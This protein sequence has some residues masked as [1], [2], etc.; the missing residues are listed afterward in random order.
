MFAPNF[1]PLL[2]AT[3][4]DSNFSKLKYPLLASPKLDGIRCLVND[5]LFSRTLK[6]IRNTVLQHSYDWKIYNGLDGEII[7]GD[8]TV[9]GIFRDTT[10]GVM[11]EFGKVDGWCYYVFDSYLDKAPFNYRL[12]HLYETL[13]DIPHIKVVS[14]KCINTPEE[15]LAYEAEMLELGY[16]GVML[17]KFGG[18]YKH[19]RSTFNEGTLIKMK[20]GH[21]QNGDA[22]IIGFTERTRNENKAVI[23]ALGLQKRSSCK[24]GLVGRGDLGSLQARDTST[25]YEFSIGTGNGL[26]DELRKEIWTNQESYLG[27]IVRYEWFAYGGYDKPRGPQFVS[28]RD[29]EDI[30]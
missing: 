30:S 3:C 27:R 11:G 21:L 8:P 20:R 23:D 14:H 1:R 16:E 9:R 15:L 22:V 12:D 19:G 7:V 28:F 18:V 25:G 5:G 26:N 13:H 10:S 17:R 4:D 29:Q 6:P 2:A 24:D